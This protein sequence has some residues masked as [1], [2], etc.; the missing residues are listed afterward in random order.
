MDREQLEA[1]RRQ[2]EEDYKLD[3]AAIE[4][5]LRRCPAASSPTASG[6]IPTSASSEPKVRPEVESRFEPPSP[7][8][9]CS[10]PAERKSDELVGSLRTIFSAGRI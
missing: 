7:V 10:G 6:S 3:I 8:L 2:L 9:P 1:L 5:L 4:R